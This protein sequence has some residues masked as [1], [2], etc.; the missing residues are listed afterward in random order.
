MS[1]TR[2]SGIDWPSARS[3]RRSSSYFPV[4]VLC[5]DS[6]DGVAEPSTIAQRLEGRAQHRDIA[7]VIARH[8]FLLV[9]VFML[10]IHEDQ[11][12]IR[13]RREHG[14]ARADHDARHALADAVPLVETLALGEIRVQHGHLVLHRGEAGLETADRL[15]CEGN[16]RHQ[17]EHGFPAIQHVPRGLQIDLGLAGTGDA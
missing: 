7:A 14:G 13:Q 11:P 10:L 5:H 17:H 1:T 6:S 8:V 3:S 2:T 4:C 15:R 9:G 16:L 12:E